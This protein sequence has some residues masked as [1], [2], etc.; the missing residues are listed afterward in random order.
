MSREDWERV[1]LLKARE[2]VKALR[3]D[4][5]SLVGQKGSHQ[6]VAWSAWV[7]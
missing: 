3:R 7:C 2:L 4:G 1:R 5:F 6:R